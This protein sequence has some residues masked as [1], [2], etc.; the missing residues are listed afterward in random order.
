M[1]VSGHYKTENCV[2]CGKKAIL[3]HG[4]VRGS[5]KA[6]LGNYV[7]KRVIAGFCD[8]HADIDCINSDEIGLYGDY[9]SKK[10]GKCLPLF[11][12]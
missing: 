3:W 7:E 9:D 8:E 1:S 5:Y 12:H 6:A 11:Q 10:M 4:S 2:I